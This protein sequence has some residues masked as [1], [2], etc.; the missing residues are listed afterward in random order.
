MEN[1]TSSPPLTIQPI[2]VMVDIQPLTSNRAWYGKRFKSKEYLK[3]E[4]DL[5]LLLP[6]KNIIEGLVEIHYDFY[7]ADKRKHD[8]DNF[9]KCLQDTI[10]KCGYITDDNN[11]MKIVARKIPAKEWKIRILILRYSSLADSF[12]ETAKRNT[13]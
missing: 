13:L 5:G 7:V 10:V 8:L 11:I 12:V 3:Y 6:R 2:E 4:R 9:I 1:K